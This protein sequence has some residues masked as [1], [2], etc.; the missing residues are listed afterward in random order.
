MKQDEFTK[1]IEK[2]FSKSLLMHLLVALMPMFGVLVWLCPFRR[3]SL[4]QLEKHSVS[5]FTEIVST[6][7]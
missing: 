1:N 7:Y 2:D 3:F 5:Q 6:R 4:P